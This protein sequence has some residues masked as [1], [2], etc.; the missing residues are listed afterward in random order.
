[1]PPPLFISFEGG[2]RSGKSTQLRTFC[3]RLADVHGLAVTRTREPGG[4]EFGRLLRDRLIHDQKHFSP[5]VEALL[6]AADRGH[7][8][9]Q[10][11]R[12][13]LAAGR[14]VVSDRYLDS[15]L[16]YQGGARG[17]EADIVRTLSEF[18]TGMLYPDLTFLLDIDDDTYTARSDGL[19][20]DKIE[21][22]GAAFQSTLRATFRDLAAADPRRFVAIDGRGDEFA[23]HDQVWSAYR[24]FAARFTA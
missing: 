20:D 2:D 3:D 7:H 21:A 4:T 24:G 11:I 13:A 10:V 8:V 5:R 9:D 14:T 16:A 15:S 1:M 17:L 18:A 19:A 22:E 12:P 6:Y 23:V